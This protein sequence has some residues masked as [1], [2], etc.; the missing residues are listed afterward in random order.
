VNLERVAIAI[1]QPEPGFARRRLDLSYRVCVALAV[2]AALPHHPL[3]NSYWADTMIVTRRRVHLAVAPCD[4]SPVRL[5]CDAQDLNLRGLARGLGDVAAEQSSADRTFTIV[6]L[7]GQVWGDP[8]AFVGG[9]AAAL[10]VG[11][12][13]VRPLAIDDGG[14]E[15]LVVRHAALLTLAYDARVLGQCHADAFLRD[16]KRRLEQFHA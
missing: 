5:I 4:G 8:S 7:G 2:I 11:A 16:I 13:R 3:L 9:G 14:V 6:D 12:V 15:R 1:A 10:G